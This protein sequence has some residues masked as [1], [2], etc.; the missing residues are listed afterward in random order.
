MTWSQ[1]ELDA[2]R[3]AYALRHVAGE[4]RRALGRV[5]L[6]GRSPAANPHHRER[7]GALPKV[8]RSRSAASRPSARADRHRA[9]HELARP[10]H[11]LRGAA[12]GAAPCPAAG[13][14][15]DARPQLR[16]R[17][18]RPADRRLG[19]RRHQRQ[20][21]DRHGAVAP[22][23]PLA[24]SGAQQP[25]RGEG[26]AGGGQQPGRHRHPAAG[27]IRRCRRQRDGRQALGPLRREPATPTD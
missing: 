26:G 18:R 17:A 15:R 16:G 14:D 5:R 24:R 8:G 12:S 3:K 4:L 25:V 19:G 9:P 13:G 22:A 20:R 11:R 1:A 7:D 23:R 27:A 10:R 6:G 2:L 21:R